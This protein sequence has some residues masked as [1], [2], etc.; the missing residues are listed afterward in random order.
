MKL[1]QIAAEHA[2]F[3]WKSMQDVI[4]VRRGA[5]ATITNA[6]VN[7]VTGKTVNHNA[8][9]LYDGVNAFGENISKLKIETGNTGCPTAIFAWTGYNFN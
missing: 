9:Q 1:A 8:T 6:L 3:Q 2:D 5:K 7:P 4:K